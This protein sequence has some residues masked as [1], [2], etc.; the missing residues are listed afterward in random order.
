MNG[1]PTLAIT[2]PMFLLGLI[3]FHLLERYGKPIQESGATG[4]MRRGYF[5]DFTAA[6]V[7][8][9]VL[10]GLTKVGVYWII[11]R[12][13]QVGGLLGTWPW[14]AQFA[15]FLLVNDF[16]R[17]WLHRWYHVS[18]VLWR[19]HR[20]H[21]TAVEMDALST[22]RVHV[23]EAVIKYGV[24]ILPFHVLGVAKSATVIYICVDILKGFWH[25]ANL[26]TYIG[27]LNYVLN[28]AELHWHHHSIEGRGMFANYGSIFSIWDWLFRTAYWPRGEWPKVIGVRSMEAFPDTYLGQ[29]ASVTLS[30]AEAARQYCA[31]VD[32]EATVAPA[33]EPAPESSATVRGSPA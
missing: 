27:P 26:R 30:D 24:I 33:T 22:F 5:A 15:L 31:H 20:V 4:P 11:A 13:P 28:S 18:P 8:G 25:H 32:A 17:Y 3:V 12:M 2:G 6:V 19:I 29:F 21:H 9:P 7:N 10:S 1:I 14:V 23:L 16:M